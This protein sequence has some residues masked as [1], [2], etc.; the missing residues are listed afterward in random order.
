MFLSNKV[1]VCVCVYVCIHVCMST[2]KWMFNVHLYFFF[3]PSFFYLFFVGPRSLNWYSSVYVCIYN[4]FVTFEIGTGSLIF[5]FLCSAT[6]QP[7][8]IAHSF[9]VYVYVCGTCIVHLIY[10]CANKHV[11]MCVSIKVFLLLLV[12]MCMVL[13]YILACCASPFESFF[14]FSLLLFF[15]SLHLVVWVV[16]LNLFSYVFWKVVC[17]ILFLLLRCCCFSQCFCCWSLLL[18]FQLCT[19]RIFVFVCLCVRVWVCVYKTSYMFY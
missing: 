2:R 9:S 16:S 13:C 12:R 3:L 7:S 17:A 6:R 10:Q 14:S 4:I 5:Y 15:I 18:V 8:S 1:C 11:W 19:V